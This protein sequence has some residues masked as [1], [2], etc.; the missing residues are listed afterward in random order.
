MIAEPICGIPAKDDEMSKQEQTKSGVLG[1]GAAFIVAASL[2][3]PIGGM[4]GV[5]HA[6]NPGDPATDTFTVQ[7]TISSEARIA[8]LDDV[9]FGSVSSFAATDQTA[10]EVFTIQTNST[11][12]NYTVT[13]TSDQGSFVLNDGGTNDISYAIR[14]DDDN[15]AS[16]G[17][18]LTYGTASSSYVS[19]GPSSTLNSS[20]HLTIPAAQL[21]T[22]AGTYS[23]VL[24]VSVD[25]I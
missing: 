24:T 1:V 19:T 5:A 6:A 9:D 3:L 17:E 21:Q 4:I 13:V 23:S 18:A 7:I 15:D 10:L 11:S 16:D 20:F 25:I 2:I 22:P 8:D 12:D 14:Y